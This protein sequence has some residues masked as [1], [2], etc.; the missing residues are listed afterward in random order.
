MNL[1]T[2]QSEIK[3]SNFLPN[4]VT[5]EMAII[6]NFYSTKSTFFYSKKSS[7][8]CQ[9][10]EL[11]TVFLTKWSIKGQSLKFYSETKW[12]MECQ[13]LKLSTPQSE[14]LYTQQSGERKDDFYER[15]LWNNGFVLHGIKALIDLS[16][17]KMYLST[18]T[19]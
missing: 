9:S 16:L 8:K 13:S 14:Q 1:C 12:R 18:Q 6:K 19:F 15:F 10:I 7:K 4:K 17:P 3:I 5:K 2:P 11:S